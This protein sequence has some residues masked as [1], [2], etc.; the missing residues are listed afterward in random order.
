M[1]A[2]TAKGEGLRVAD[3]HTGNHLEDD[4]MPL[5]IIRRLCGVFGRRSHLGFEG[6]TSKPKGRTILDAPLKYIGLYTHCISLANLRFPLNDFF[7]S[8]LLSMIPSFPT[9]LQSH[10]NDGQQRPTIFVG[11]KGI[12]LSCFPFHLPFLLIYDLFFHFAKMSFR[13]FIYIEEDEDLT[14]LPKD[15]SLGFNNGSP[16]VSINTKPVRT[17]EEPATEP[18]TKHVNECVGTI[19]DSVGSPK[20]DTFVVHARSVVAYI[21][22]RKCKTRGGSSRPPVKRKLASGLK[23]CL[24]LKDATAYHLKISAITP[25]AWMGFLDNHLDVDLLELHDCCYVR[26]A[27]V[28]NAVNRRSRE[29]LEESAE[30]K[31]HKGNLDTL[32]LESQKWSGYQEIKEAKHDRREVVSKV[33]PYACM[34]LI[35]SDELGR[36]I[37][38]LVSSVI[39]FGRCKAYEQVARMKEPFD[40]S[41]VNGYRPSYKK[42]HTQA[43]NNLATATFSLLNEY[44]ADAS[45]SIEA[46]LSKKPPTL[47]KPVPSRTQ[48]HVPSTQQATPSSVPSLKP[49]SPPTDIVKP[50]PSQMN[51]CRHVNVNLALRV[52]CTR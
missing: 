15:L 19:A 46:L 49:M 43:S 33:V 5:K 52:E 51:E 2:P 48:I 21:R 40:L 38:K 22:E 42:D 13:N 45:A 3:S 1:K 27:I 36:R 24:E 20:G 10:G 6:E 4:F 37:G 41:K 32:M 16:F 17:D 12:Y 50:S 25:P 18:T 14:F 7:F 34:K 31:E 35:H 9:C 8:V 11:G 23:D 39:T 44:V 26:Q 47:Q 28:D 29:L 30:V